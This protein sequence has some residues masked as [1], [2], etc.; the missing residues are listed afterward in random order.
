MFKKAVAKVIV[1]FAHLNIMSMREAAAH[2]YDKTVFS[3]LAL[4]T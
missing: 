4:T 3:Y 2:V 1:F